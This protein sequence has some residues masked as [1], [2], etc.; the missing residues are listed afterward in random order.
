MRAAVFLI[1]VGTAAGVQAA[2]EWPQFLGP[3]GDSHS[4]A[5]GLPVTW[6]E[7][8]NV[9]WKTPLHGR[10]WSSPVIWDNQIWMTTATEDGKQQFALCVDRE[11]GK[12][13]HDIHLFD[14]EKPS[15]IHVLNSY[16]SPSAVIEE[17]RVYITFGSYGTACLDTKTAEVLWKRRDLPCEHFRGPGSSPILFGNLLI[18]HYDGFDF[19]Y[20][21]ALD[22]RTGDTVWKSDR[23]IDYGSENGDF[24]KAF[25]TP[26]VFDVNGRLELISPTS[27]A[28]MSLDPLTGKEFWRIRYTQFSVAAK[29]IYDPLRQ[30]FYINTG[31]GKADL[32]AVR[33]GG[34]GDVTDTHVAW[35]SSK[36]IPSKPT[37]LLVGDALYMIHDA[38]T[39]TCLDAATG[40]VVWQQRVGGNFSASPLY[41]EGRIYLL[42]QEG[43]TTVIA[44]SRDYKVLAEN[45][46]DDGFMSSPAV[47]GQSL[48]LRTR[49]ALYRIEQPTAK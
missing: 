45:K 30:M 21:I 16:A 35:K 14:N 40:D 41:A 12:I 11:T 47:A 4:T 8:E 42:S 38:G 5:T 18:Q 20:I 9:V 25:C 37:Q 48:F 19:Q 46:L 31:F 10:G 6:S 34:E 49:S 17:G 2:G 28:T 26:Q 13:L 32:Y 23:D 24:K 3:T 33:T 29:P 1:V 36:S 43:P 22:K 44:A 15:E 39:A 7:S 27:K